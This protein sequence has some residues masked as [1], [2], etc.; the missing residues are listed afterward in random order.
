[1]LKSEF[2]FR[3]MLLMGVRALDATY[4]PMVRYLL[5]LF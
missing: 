2:R 1:M 3:T 4:L 5:E